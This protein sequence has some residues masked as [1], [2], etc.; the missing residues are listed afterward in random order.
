M[1]AFVY[2]SYLAREKID[3]ALY[4]RV[5]D[6][7]SQ[8]TSVSNTGDFFRVRTHGDY[9]PYNI[10]VS[11]D[12]LTVLDPIADAMFGRMDN[13]CSRYEDIVHFFSFV[14]EMSSTLIS[15]KKKGQFLAAFR[16]G[17]LKASGFDFDVQS[18]VF[19]GYLIKY[20]LLRALDGRA[21]FLSRIIGEYGRLA[22]FKRNFDRRPLM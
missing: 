7:V 4:L 19:L 18:D 20:R 10:L 8:I 1:F 6:T 9:A 14:E 21:S 3:K 15:K 16:E 11:K 17:Y 5:I 22:H 12:G 13:Y 2:T